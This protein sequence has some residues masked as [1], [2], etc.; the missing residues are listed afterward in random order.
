M[1]AASTLPGSRWCSVIRMVIYIRMVICMLIA[2]R[3][4]RP[5][6]LP[7]TCLL[8][9]RLTA[10]RRGLQS[11]LMIARGGIARMCVS[12]PLRFRPLPRNLPLG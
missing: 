9:H 10:V 3:L 8:S 6:A 4:T 1:E 12:I 11:T 2:S 5:T 7:C